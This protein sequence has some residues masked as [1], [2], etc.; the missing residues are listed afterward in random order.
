MAKIEVL[1]CLVNALAILVAAYGSAEASGWNLAHATF[2]GDMSGAETMRMLIYFYLII[3]DSF[4]FILILI[5]ILLK[6]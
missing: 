6:I 1:I 4:L 2:Y 3:I 5:L